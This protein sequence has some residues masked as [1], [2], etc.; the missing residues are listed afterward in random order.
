MLKLAAIVG[1]T[2]VGKTGIALKAARMMGAEIISCDS[3][4]VYRGMDIGTA[5]AAR[6]QQAIVKH[7]LLDVADIGSEYSVAQ[8]QQSAAGIIQILNDQGKIPLLVGGTGLYYQAVVDNYQLFP[9]K[10]RQEVRE[11]YNQQISLKGIEYVY[12][13]LQAVDPSYA[14]K[15]SPQDQKRIVRALEVYELTGQPFSLFQT[16][17][18]DSYNFAAAGLYMERELLYKRIEQRVDEM[19]KA[20]LIDEVQQ[21]I[22]AGYNL[23][24][25][26]MQALGYKQVVY[27]LQGLLTREQMLDDIKRETRRYAK[28]QYTWFNRDKKIY[29]FD[30]G[31]FS[32][33][34]LLAENISAYLEGQLSGV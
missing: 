17:K 4:Q 25:K 15:I 29:W 27:Y 26:P 21:L 9:L 14:Q 23:E 7:H 3:M 11:K 19:F 1:P 18:E 28:R 20:G 2:A 22:K 31:K 32:D 16:K 12:G 5:K 10:S 24:N 30:T 8:Y 6:E 34:Q 13:Q 33:E